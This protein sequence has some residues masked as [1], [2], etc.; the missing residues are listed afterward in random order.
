MAAIGT[1][2]TEMLLLKYGLTV[3]LE[4]FMKKVETHC[5]PDDDVAEEGS[6]T[7][8]EMVERVNAWPDLRF[9]VSGGNG[10]LLALNFSTQSLTFEGLCQQVRAM[11]GTAC[12]VAVVK[13]AP[14][15]ASVQ[16]EEPT[17]H[18]VSVFR[19]DYSTTRALI[20]RSS[21]SCMEPLVRIGLDNFQAA[22]LVDPEI[23]G[24]HYRPSRMEL[25]GGLV[26]I[27]QLREEYL[28]LKQD[29]LSDRQFA[30]GVPSMSTPRAAAA[31]AAETT[32][33]VVQTAFNPA[34]RGLADALLE[35]RAHDAQQPSLVTAA[36]DWLWGRSTSTSTVSSERP[37]QGG[38][39]PPG[40]QATEYP[41]AVTREASGVGLQAPAGDLG[42]THHWL[43]ISQ[44]STGLSRPSM[45]MMGDRSRATVG[46]RPLPYYKSNPDLQSGS[47]PV[48]GKH[49]EVY[50]EPLILVPG[51]PVRGP[52]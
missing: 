19:E 18:A 26:T 43:Q 14:P 36:V 32:D 50:R 20:G 28:A 25:S 2:V 23:V 15:E 44:P 3:E 13:Q 45:Q 40:S 51:R 30:D 48:P 33:E 29:H 49:N 27:P 34:R 22:I 16:E 17:F 1:V 35:R 41:A 21:S 7:P 42:A 38:S 4:D 39:L 11:V 12:A 52:R 46:G 6:P 47:H 8:S 9:Q 10:R 37:W 24:V 5:L 31:T